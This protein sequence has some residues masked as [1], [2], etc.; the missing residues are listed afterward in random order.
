[1]LPHREHAGDRAEHEPGAADPH[2][3]DSERALRASRDALAPVSALAGCEGA[4]AG[5][6]A[7][8]PPAAGA[9]TA[10]TAAAADFVSVSE[11]VVEPASATVKVVWP[12]S[13]PS[14][15]A[16]TTCEPGSIGRFTPSAA[17]GT[18]LSSI[19]TFGSVGPVIV[20]VTV[21][22]RACTAPTSA[23]AAA[24][25]STNTCGAPGATPSRTMR[26]YAS[27]AFTTLPSPASARA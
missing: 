23:F 20:S 27:A 8:G 17:V 22:M 2:P 6:A 1:M 21:A 15:V 24:S 14:A 10:A 18:G 7:S 9:G 3:H 11:T 16:F 4:P 12:G 25:A 13:K 26:L 5:A 19:V